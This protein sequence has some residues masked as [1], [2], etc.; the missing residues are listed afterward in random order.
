MG[1]TNSQQ[2]AAS[3]LISFL[4]NQEQEELVLTSGAGYGKTHLVSWFVNEGYS[5][6]LQICAENQIP[7]LF[8][9]RPVVT[10]TTNKAAEVLSTKLRVPADTIHSYLGV[11]VKEDYTTGT[12]YLQ[13]GD[14]FSPKFREIVFID[15]C[16]MIDT[17]L[18]Q[19]IKEALFNC[20][21]IYVGDKDQLAPVNSDLSP[22][23]SPEIPQIELTENVRLKNHPEML[24]L[25]E[26]LKT[27][28]RTGIFKPIKTKEG[29]IE[30]LDGNRMQSLVNELF[31]TPSYDN[32]IVTYTNKKA[33]AYNDYIKYDL[34]HYESP[35]VVGEHYIVNSV[36]LVPETYSKKKVFNT[37][38]EIVIEEIGETTVY[39]NCLVPF[40]IIQLKARNYLGNLIT[41]Y[42]P[43]NSS[44]FLASLKQEARCKRWKSYFRAKETIA[45]L[46]LADSSTVHKAQGSTYKNI[47]VDLSDLSSCR[48]YDTV[49]RLLYVACTRATD[50][51][52]LYGK[53]AD[54]FG[55]VIG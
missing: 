51:V 9:K 3:K 29:V 23:F 19:L 52:Y 22:V 54:K 33:L 55:G 2:E 36:L 16:S 40:E 44:Q 41:F 42:A 35:F 50:H 12:T 20:K 37:E 34:R 30:L 45:D 39:T 28:V 31:L 26:Q 8:D 11:I 13:K 18:Y 5:R 47:F 32:K 25:A 6:Y 48:S 46:R 14:N 1:L 21:I 24:E 38:D 4:L 27:T 49:A 53:L 7:V 17:Q 43:R 15:E 10:A